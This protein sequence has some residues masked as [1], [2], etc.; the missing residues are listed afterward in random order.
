[1]QPPVKIV[2]VKKQL[3]WK[4]NCHLSSSAKKVLLHFFHHQKQLRNEKVKVPD[5]FTT[6]ELSSNGTNTADIRNYQ[7]FKIGQSA[8]VRNG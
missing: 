4:Q 2:L 7:G 3:Y 5:V 1:M 8:T 6:A